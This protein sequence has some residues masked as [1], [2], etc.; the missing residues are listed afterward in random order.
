MHSLE[1]CEGAE[2][3]GVSVEDFREEQRPVAASESLLEPRMPGRALHERRLVAVVVE[4]HAQ[5]ETLAYAAHRAG[6]WPAC[7]IEGSER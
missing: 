3:A 5:H 6:D 1:L 2:Q 7:P 4:V